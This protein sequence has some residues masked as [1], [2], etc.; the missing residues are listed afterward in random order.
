MQIHQQVQRIEHPT[1][2]EI[3][4]PRNYMLSILVSVNSKNNFWLAQKQLFQLPCTAVHKY[5]HNAS[6]HQC[7][8]NLQQTWQHSLLG[9]KV[10]EP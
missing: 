1:I 3:Y 5:A 8:K 7:H 4:G 10:A 6:A 2:S 9:V